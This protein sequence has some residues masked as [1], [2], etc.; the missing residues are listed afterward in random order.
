VV[1]QRYIGIAAV[2]A[3]ALAA[4]S[5]ECPTPR[6]YSID[7]DQIFGRYVADFGLADEEFVELLPNARYEH[8]YRSP[9][10]EVFDY[11]SNYDI[12]PPSRSIGMWHIKLHD[13]KR[14]DPVHI[15]CFDTTASAE[16]DTT[17]R[18]WIP[19]LYKTH[20]GRLLIQY[21][22]KRQQ[23]YVKQGT[24]DLDHR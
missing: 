6:S 11:K 17:P 4:G 20:D 9:S 19:E 24:T 3:L 23:S 12:I 1:A 13:F 15:G 16:V 2:L 18:C 10:G 7:R 22:W 21:C 14:W 5:C 8:Y